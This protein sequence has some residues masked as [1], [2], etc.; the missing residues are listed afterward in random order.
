MRNFSIDCNGIIPATTITGS[1]ISVPATI[2]GNNIIVE[3]IDC[4]NS[5]YS[6]SGESF[7]FSISRPAFTSS[8]T[9]TTGSNIVRNCKFRNPYANRG[10]NN[11]FYFISGWGNTTGSLQDCVIEGCYIDGLDSF[12]SSSVQGI[13]V[14]AT[15]SYP[16]GCYGL[17]VRNNTIKNSL[18]GFYC[19]TLYTTGSN[20]KFLNNTFYPQG[21]LVGGSNG[22]W[23]ILTFAP[24]TDLLIS[25]NLF[26]NIHYGC[27]GTN[28][29]G[30]IQFQ[31]GS[32]VQIVDNQFIASFV[33]SSDTRLFWLDISTGSLASNILVSNNYVA[34]ISGSISQFNIS[35]Q[36]I[37]SSAFISNTSSIVATNNYFRSDF[38]GTYYQGSV[39]SLTSSYTSTPIDNSFTFFGVYPTGSINLGGGFSSPIK[40]TQVKAISNTGTGSI[41]LLK[42]NVV[43]GSPFSFTSSLN[44]SSYSVTYNPTDTIQVSM[45]GVTPNCRDLGLTITY[46]R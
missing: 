22:G 33:S 38:G 2:Y 42:N 34:A 4:Y 30:H 43:Q 24:I 29:P 25:N 6:G 39:Y 14:F 46:N 26:S 3:N 18:Y 1:F 11:M 16:G 32:N 35:S 8:L 45:S 15:D 5:Y 9:T 12:G 28:N 13:G 10:N 36:L 17:T 7:G 27:N 21:G 44:S 37:N 20:W 31:N 40:L 19:D 23:G 41:Q